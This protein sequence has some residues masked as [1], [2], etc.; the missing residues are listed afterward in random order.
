MQP[1]FTFHV[2]CADDLHQL[3]IKFFLLLVEDILVFFYSLNQHLGMED[4]DTAVVH[5]WCGNNILELILIDYFPTQTYNTRKK[6]KN[7]LHVQ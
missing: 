1:I 5:P 6:I 4:G 2:F 3:E 7:T